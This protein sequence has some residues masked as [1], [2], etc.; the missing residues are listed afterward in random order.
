M[1]NEGYLYDFDPFDSLINPPIDPPIDD[2]PD[3]NNLIN[4]PPMY[5]W[6][7][8]NSTIPYIIDQ[9]FTQRSIG[10]VRDLFGLPGNEFI[11]YYSLITVKN[12]C[13]YLSN[14]DFKNYVEQEQ[15]TKFFFFV[16]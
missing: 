14:N 6:V 10:N 5:T 16:L 8:E 2:L 13:G 4:N 3:Y 11:N 9:T 1:T 12:F 15:Q 7:I